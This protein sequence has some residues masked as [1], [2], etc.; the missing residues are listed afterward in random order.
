VAR[1]EEPSVGIR[2]PHISKNLRNDGSRDAAQAIGHMRY[3]RGQEVSRWTPL[4]SPATRKYSDAPL[5]VP[6]L[7]I[8]FLTV[9]QSPTEHGNT[10]K[11][12]A[13]M[14]GYL[15]PTTKQSPLDKVVKLSSRVKVLREATGQ[16]AGLKGNRDGLSLH[17]V[18]PKELPDATT[19]RGR[20]TQRPAEPAREVFRTPELLEAILVHLVPAPLRTRYTVPDWPADMISEPTLRVLLTF[21]KLNRS[22]APFPKRFCLRQSCNVPSF[23]HRTEA[24]FSG[25]CSPVA[26]AST[27]TAIFKAHRE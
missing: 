5:P 20:C 26:L 14:E 19:D 9:H 21:Y 1:D 24:H 12:A 6:T 10:H 7:F 18:P 25:R 17:N 3:R 16:V 11:K 8:T 4:A 2:T 27:F 22:I 13:R 23:W 15:T